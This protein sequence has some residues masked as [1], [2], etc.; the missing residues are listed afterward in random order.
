M[1]SMSKQPERDCKG[2]HS[3]KAS[4]P[5]QPSAAEDTGSSLNW[6]PPLVQNIVRHPLDPNLENYPYDD[7]TSFF[8]GAAFSP[9]PWVA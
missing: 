1:G 9:R 8:P 4:I 3:S 2:C 5:R 7:R 6:G